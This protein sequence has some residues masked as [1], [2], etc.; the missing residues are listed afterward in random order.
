M[1][2]HNER[3]FI[4]KNLK[5]Y[6]RL[7]L[8][9]SKLGEYE[10]LGVIKGFSKNESEFYDLVAV[11]DMLKMISALGREEELRAFVA[12]Y[13]NGRGMRL[14]RHK[15]DVSNNAL[16]FAMKTHLDVRTVYR[17]AAYIEALY[18]KIRGNYKNA[19]S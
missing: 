5:K 17:R 12:L 19:G 9:K 18:L 10:R 2:L 4:A 15:N 3:I 14:V 16:R 6:A 7:G 8:P 1:R 13:M 11:S